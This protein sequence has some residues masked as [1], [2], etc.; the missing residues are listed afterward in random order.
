MDRQAFHAL[1]GLFTIVKIAE[2]FI[3]YSGCF[4]DD[5]S[6]RRIGFL[7]RLDL[8]DSKLGQKSFAIST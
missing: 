5:F 1:V 2:P 3:V 4:R 6:I 8:V 7:K